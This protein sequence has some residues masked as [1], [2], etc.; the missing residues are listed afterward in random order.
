MLAAGTPVGCAGAAG[1][2]AAGAAGAG[3]AAGAADATG[4]TP[5]AAISTIT[6]PTRA[7]VPSDTKTAVIVPLTGEGI[8]S[9]DLSF[10]TSNKISSSAIVSPTLTSIL[11]IS[12]SAIPSPIS[13]NLNWNTPAAGA[14]GALAA[15]AAAGA[16]SAG[17]EPSSITTIMSP[18]RATVPS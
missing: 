2:L 13:G 4:A 14:A 3:L 5:S 7:T 11:T 8:S 18:T 16:A 12:P 9:T 6:S 15:G 1:V 17:P 10:C